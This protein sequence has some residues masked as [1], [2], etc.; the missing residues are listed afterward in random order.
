MKIV[1]INNKMFNSKIEMAQ[2]NN[3]LKKL[4]EASRLPEYMGELLLREI[5]LSDDDANEH[6]RERAVLL[7]LAKVVYDK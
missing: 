7:G 2:H 4:T 5:I 3:K 1:A 6:L